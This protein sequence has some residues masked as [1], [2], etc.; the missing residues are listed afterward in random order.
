[1]QGLIAALAA[2]LGIVVGY[3]LRHLSASNEK[4]AADNEKAQLGQRTAQLSGDLDSMRTELKD[5]RELAERR[6]G[7]ESLCAE[8]QAIIDRLTAEREKTIASL[9]A[10]RDQA[11]AT[12]QA[13]GDCERTLSARNSQLEADLRNERQN[14]QEKVALLETAKKSLADQFQALASEILDQKS[15]TFAEVSQND[16]NALLSPLRDQIGEFRKKVEESQTDSKLGVNTLQTLIGNLNTMNQQLSQEARNLST[17]L[18]GSA[19]TQGD[20]GEFILRDLLENS[21]LREGEQY[22]FQQRFTYSD[23]EESR[24]TAIT[25]VVIQLPGERHLI[26]D[27]KVSLDAYADSVN[28]ENDIDRHAALKRHISSIRTHVSD[29]AGKRYQELLSLETLDF[30]VMF[31]PIEPAFFEA[32]RADDRLWADA[33]KSKVLLVGPT[34]LLFVVRIVHELWAQEVKAQNYKEVMDRGSQLYDKFVGFLADL[35]TVGAS[36]NTALDSFESAK[37]KLSTSDTSLVYQV[38]RLRALGV[39][40]KVK[41]TRKKGSAPALIPQR[42]LDGSITDSRDL[43]LASEVELDDVDLNEEDNNDVVP[44]AVEQQ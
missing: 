13:K 14:L 16:L 5:I 18:R 27:S 9:T 4:L 2:V 35:E 1:M 3:W 31:V 7:F 28:A 19:K 10:E 6:A 22:T 32:L 15:R 41:K 29:L 40:P 33:Y 12:V 37:K 39:T 21:G 17:A 8:R 34:T 38:E 11:H 43:F 44:E 20:W 23:D 42:W 36:L 30:V 24:K 25:D 26:I